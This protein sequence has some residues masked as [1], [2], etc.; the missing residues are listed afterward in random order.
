[1]Y[2]AQKFE[3]GVKQRVEA[4]VVGFDFTILLTVLLP[5]IMDAI[6]GCFGANDTNSITAKLVGGKDDYWVKRQVHIAIR[7]ELKST[8]QKLSMTE[9]L[10]LRDSVLDEWAADPAQTQTMVN[11][12]KAVE[13]FG[14]L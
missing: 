2:A 9:Q 8:G 13:E 6:K 10:A 4:K 12:M 14:M 5:V 11:E 7:R 3:Q 1:M